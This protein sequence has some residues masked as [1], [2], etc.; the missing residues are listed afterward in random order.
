MARASRT[1]NERGS[2]L[3]DA[4]ERDAF[5]ALPLNR[6]IQEAYLGERWPTG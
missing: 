1:M 2:V 3:T 6:E 4:G 5:Y